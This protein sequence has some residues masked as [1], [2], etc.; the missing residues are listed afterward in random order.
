MH[1]ARLGFQ[2]V[3][4]LTARH[5][6]LPVAGE[7]A[8]WLRAVRRGEVSFEEW[9]QRCLALDAQLEQMA[10]DES[11]PEGSDRRRIESWSVATHLSY[12]TRA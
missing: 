9:W 1:A 5:L 8:E 4:L 12:W 10:T 6:Q 7:P 11:L 2:G 3:E